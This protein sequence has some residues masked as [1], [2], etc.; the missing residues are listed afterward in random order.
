MGKEKSVMKGFLGALI[1]CAVMFA[2]VYFLFP[3]ASEKYFGMSFKNG[4]VSAK[5]AS[6]TAEITDMVADIKTELKASGATD[7]Q[8]SKI[9]DE[10]KNSDVWDTIKDGASDGAQAVSSFVKDAA[11]ELD[12]NISAESISKAISS[13]DFKKLGASIASFASGAIDTIMDKIN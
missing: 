13:I 10:L 4:D 7:E 11:K 2:V 6:S 3:N 8:I 12:I 9:I 5:M 1:L